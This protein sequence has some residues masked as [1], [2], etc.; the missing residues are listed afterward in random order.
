MSAD[1]HRTDLRRILRSNTYDLYE[2][3]SSKLTNVHTHDLLK[4]AKGSEFIMG[5]NRKCSFGLLEFDTQ[6][7]DPQVKYSIV[8]IDNKLID[9]RVLKL[10]QLSDSN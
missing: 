4:N 1:R 10:S 9:S 5:Y 3:M 6:L 8:N 7:E 2:V